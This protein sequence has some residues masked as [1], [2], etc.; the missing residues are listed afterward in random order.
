MS[1]AKAEKL[2]AD[3]LKRVEDANGR[4]E[5][6][7][8]VHEA[9]IFGSYLNDDAKN[10]G[11]LDIAIELRLRQIR[12][13]DPVKHS[14]DR[15]IKAQKAGR[16]FRSS[17]ELMFFGEIEVRQLLK[18]RGPYISLHPMSDLEATNAASRLIYKS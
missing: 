1:R 5:L 11:D 4:D 12:G 6:S 8:Y 18:G 13:R 16:R 15:G 7:H 3:F 17:V 14:Q 9:H 2:L 10:L